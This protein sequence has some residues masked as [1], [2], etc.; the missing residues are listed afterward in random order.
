ML[1]RPKKLNVPVQK[2]VTQI[3]ITLIGD[4]QTGKTSF[5]QRYSTNSCPSYYELTLGADSID[6][7]VTLKGQQVHLA[8]WDM[9]GRSDFL[10]IRNEIY[11]ETHLVMLF[12]DLSN[13]STIESVDYWLREVKDHNGACPLYIVG[14]K[15]DNKKNSP[16]LGKA[17]QEREGVYAEVSCKTGDGVDSLMEKIINDFK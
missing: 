12:V 11:K 9:S 16:D 2:E 1:E 3:K 7:H 8:F 14:N 10:E 4:P 6:K 13:K 5:A 17:A 15:S